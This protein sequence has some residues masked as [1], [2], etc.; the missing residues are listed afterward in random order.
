MRVCFIT[1]EIFH[2]GAHGGFGALTR[3]IGRELVKRKVEVY[4]VMPQSSVDQ[5]PIETLDGM[6]ILSVRSRDT[7]FSLVPSLRS[8]SFLKL[9][10][11]DIYHSE[12]PSVATY[13]ATKVNP[14]KRHIVTVQ[15]PRDMNDIKVQLANAHAERNFLMKWLVCNKYKTEGF[16]IKKALHRAD[17]V[18]SQAKYV[19]PKA[20]KMYSLK[21]TPTFLPNPVEIPLRKMRKAES[22]TVCFLARWDPLKRIEI[23]FDLAKRFPSI[24]F[25][26]LGKSH[27]KDRD[28]SLRRKWSSLP[29]V[30][31][32][33]FVSER[34]KSEILEKS[35]I[36]INTSLRECLP[37]AFLEACA[38]KCAILSCN[39]PDDFA[40]DFGFY[41]RN[42]DFSAGLRNLLEDMRWKE[43]GER[44]FEYVKEVHELRKVIDQHIDI[45]NRL[46]SN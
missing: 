24:K 39:N 37:V 14:R 17:A 16:L 33:G 34:K 21:K 42:G 11:A 2:W 3:A 30:E 26:A 10:D 36:M 28:N 12:E 22:P 7:Y 41:V 35:W 38:H 27:C 4:V 20:T 13:I 32:P 43:K 6:T 9:C 45:Y 8:R 5:R 29:N 40:S 44:G 18:F 46:L 15:D 23:F 31:M 19:I 25:I 1:G